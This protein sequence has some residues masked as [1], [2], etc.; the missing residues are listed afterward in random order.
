MVG[1]ARGEGRVYVTE[2]V[3]DVALGAS[4]GGCGVTRVLGSGRIGDLGLRPGC[5]RDSAPPRQ[6]KSSTGSGLSGWAVIL[7]V[8]REFFEI[9]GCGRN[10]KL[11]MCRLRRP[12]TSKIFEDAVYPDVGVV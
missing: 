3:A 8:V 10:I 6:G 9:V 11:L 12:S 4:I 7:S 5:V 1:V 2:V